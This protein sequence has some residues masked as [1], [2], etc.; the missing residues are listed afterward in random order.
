[1]PP[2]GTLPFKKSKAARVAEPQGSSLD[3]MGV[4]RGSRELLVSF[5]ISKEHDVISREIFFK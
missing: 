1:L 5:A 2:E 3:K 4:T